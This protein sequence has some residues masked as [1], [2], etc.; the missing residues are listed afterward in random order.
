MLDCMKKQ[1]K[2][3]DNYNVIQWAK[4]Y[5]IVSR[6]FFMIGFPGET[7]E[8]LE[9]TKR[10]IEESDPDQYFVSNFVPYPGTDVY[11]NPGD[12]G[13]TNLSKDYD[14]YFQV[15]KD[16]TG[17]L[18]IDTEWLTK[19]QFRDLELEFREWIKTRSMRG[20]K[21]NYES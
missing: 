9:E 18:T 6:A 20:E 4:K 10:F 3:Q 17:G 1:V 13:I 2:V 7:R 16:G 11:D 14:Q 21:Q 8:T 19:E 5:G 15:S 12:Y